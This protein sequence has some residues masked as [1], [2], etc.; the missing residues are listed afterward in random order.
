M[1]E[2]IFIALL[3]LQ[4]LIFFISNSFY[5][6]FSRG[7]NHNIRKNVNNKY[8]V[9]LVIPCYNE[10]A[11]IK[12]K[13]I[14][15]LSL[16]HPNGPFRIYVVDDGSTDNTL[17]IAKEFK[18]LNKTENLFIWKHP[19]KKGKSRALNWVF[20]KIKESII[21]ITDVDVLLKK[22]SLVNLIANFR[23]P[24]VGAVNGKIIVNEQNVK[25]TTN[26]ESFV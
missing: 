3:L 11:V 23:D 19:E 26:M 20:R 9:A 18:R 6:C 7:R 5:F 22:D 17:K 14:N 13:L 2:T 25:I 12:R 4:S 1:I 24:K 21:V 16:A 8:S 10:E 15:S